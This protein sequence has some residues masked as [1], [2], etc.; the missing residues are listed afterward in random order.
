MAV[1]RRRD[2]KPTPIDDEQRAVLIEELKSL[3]SSA[4]H[5]FSTF[6]TWWVFVGTINIAAMAA[7]FQPYFPDR[8]DLAMG[9]ST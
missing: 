2:P 5:C 1:R 7:R 6:V 3:Y 4:Q 9:F 8:L